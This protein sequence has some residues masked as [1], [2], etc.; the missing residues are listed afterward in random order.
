[1]NKT[2]LLTTLACAASFLAGFLL[3]H[4]WTA[5]EARPARGKHPG[6]TVASARG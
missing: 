4:L 2:R 3:G 1:M 5:F 6:F